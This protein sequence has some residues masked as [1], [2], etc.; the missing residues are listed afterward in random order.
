M[1]NSINLNNEDYYFQI[2]SYA[3][4]DRLA[5]LLY[6]KDKEL[7]ADVT[8]NLPELPIC[9]IDEGFINGDFQNCSKVLLNELKNKGIIA[10]SYGFLSYN[11]GTYEYVKFDLEKLKE[12]DS[13]GV[14][15]IE[16]LK[17]ININIGDRKS[18]V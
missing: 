15:K 12:Y 4:N 9:E 3:D 1:K 8:I 11:Y 16:D 2:T 13:I 18:V 5:I 17:D 14:S 6:D 7:Y 10:E